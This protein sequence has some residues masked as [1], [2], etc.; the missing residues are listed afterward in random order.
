MP[1][2][3]ELMENWKGYAALSDVNR[4]EGY[5]RQLTEIIDLL[6]NTS[7]LPP[8]KH[9]YLLREA[10]T[11]PDF[12]YL[13]ADV[14]GRELLAAYKGT[15]ANWPK[16]TK[17][18]KVKDFRVNKRFRMTDGDQVLP[19]VAEKGEYLA[20]SR[21]TT[22]YEIQALKYGRQFDISY[23]AIIN[24]DL[25]AIKDTPQRM[26]LAANRTEQRVIIGL[27]A[28]NVGTHGGTQLYD[29]TTPG[30]INAVKSPLTIANLETALET[31]AAV[32]DA[33]TEPILNR[34]KYLVVPPALEMTARQ[35]LTSA[36]KM[37]L[38]NAEA[39]A[40]ATPYPTTN[41]V[42]Q[43][44]IQLI[45]EPYLPILNANATDD[46]TQ[47]YLF[48]DPKDLPVLEAVRMT[49]HESP[50]VC[51]KASD[52]VTLGGGAIS[53]MTGDF[54]TDNIF[55]RVRLIFGGAKEDW[56]GTYVGGMDATITALE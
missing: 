13:F 12:A 40:V 41:V 31:M 14:L 33:N 26:A 56:R 51:M 37:W 30:E 16:Y 54:A 8:H 23:E 27:Y 36:T 9:E 4:P 45:V 48:S 32:T 52:K 6:G 18:S 35:I 15:P 11:T 7:H 34:A 49:G 43:M 47:W 42:A 39:I 17:V 53:P 19:L 10:M 20:S 44:G 38:E 29:W 3:L 25:G 2:F 22:P 5:E 1:E 21:T 50:E 28:G 55:Y 24:D 46:N